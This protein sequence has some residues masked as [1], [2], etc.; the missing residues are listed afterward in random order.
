MLLLTDYGYP[1]P[2]LGWGSFAT[3][4]LLLLFIGFTLRSVIILRLAITG[5]GNL[6]SSMIRLIVSIM[7][8]ILVKA[9]MV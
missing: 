1:M 6:I 2:A 3:I 9:F 4:A 8:I 5:E 7:G